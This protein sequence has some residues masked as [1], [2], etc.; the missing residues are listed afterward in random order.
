VNA[1]HFDA[2]ATAQDDDHQFFVAPDELTSDDLN[3]PWGQYQNPRGG[4][5]VVVLPDSAGGGQN[6]N[7]TDLQNAGPTID[8][9]VQITTT[10]EYTLYVRDTGYDGSSDSAYFRIVELQKDQGDLVRI[11]TDTRRP[12]PMVT[13]TRIV[14]APELAVGTTR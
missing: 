7:T 11:G 2:R 12:R 10:G 14:T 13:S 3:N 4:K 1:N 8:Y 9:K 6:R 5:Y